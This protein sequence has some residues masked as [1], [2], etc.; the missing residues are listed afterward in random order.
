MYFWFSVLVPAPKGLSAV[1]VNTTSAKVRWTPVPVNQIQGVFN[2]Y[3]IQYYVNGMRTQTIQT[4]T[5]RLH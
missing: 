4:D 2:N 5:V 1:L 3:K